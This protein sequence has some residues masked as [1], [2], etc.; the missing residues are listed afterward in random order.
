MT[1][2]DFF[3]RKDDLEKINEIVERAN[4]MG[5][6]MFDKLNLS[7]DLDFWNSIEPLNFQVLLDADDFN[8]THDIVGI[9][10]HIDRAKYK[11]DS[12]FLPRASRGSI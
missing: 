6:L 1:K 7:M 3:N 8:F 5:L 9:Q 2:Y 11:I 10:N 4:N 12:T